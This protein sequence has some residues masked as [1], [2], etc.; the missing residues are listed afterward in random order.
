MGC[1]VT[2]YSVQNRSEPPVDA[3][4]SHFSPSH[5]VV[6]SRSLCG[7]GQLVAAQQCARSLVGSEPS[8][9]VS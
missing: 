2:L 9:Y 1:K 4:T 3:V 8:R 5:H 7:P 6:Q